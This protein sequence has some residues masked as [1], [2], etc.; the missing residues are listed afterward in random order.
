MLSSNAMQDRTTKAISCML[1]SQQVQ[2]GLHV[3]VHAVLRSELGISEQCEVLPCHAETCK[4]LFA[5]FQHAV[6]ID[7]RINANIVDKVCDEGVHACNAKSHTV[8]PKDTEDVE[9]EIAQ[10]S[11][12]MYEA[13][14][15]VHA[16]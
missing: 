3:C 6:D 10:V 14:I 16:S 12:A 1:F 11:H 7:L 2:A 4:A 5:I 8:H 9:Q 15:T 13:V